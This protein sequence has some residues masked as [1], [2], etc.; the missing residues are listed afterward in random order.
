[1]NRIARDDRVLPETR[2]VSAL[3]VP[4]LIAGFVI[5]YLFPNDTGRLFAWT[6]EPRMTPLVMGAGYVAGAY[7]LARAVFAARAAR[8]RARLP[9]HRGVHLPHGAGYLLPL[10]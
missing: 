9:A 6:I 2:V 5:L 3:I 10:G 4:F 1:M 8:G 7:L